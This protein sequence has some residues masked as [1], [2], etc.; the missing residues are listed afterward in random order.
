MQNEK[1]C[2]YYLRTG[3]CKFG[4]T[5]KFHHPQPSNA[6]VSI[7]GSSVYTT[8]PSPGIPG[9][10]PYSGGLTNWP[11]SRASFITG[12]RWQGPSSYAQLI[13]PQGMV[14]V[15]GWNAYPV[16][17]ISF[18]IFCLPL[19]KLNPVVGSA[20]EN[21]PVSKT[22]IWISLQG[23]M[24]SAVS[25]PGNQQQTPPRT[26]QF[27]G[28]SQQSEIT[29]SGGQGSVSS[30]QVSSVPMGVY[31]FHKENLFPERPG[32]QE[33]QY[34]MKTGDCKFGAVCRFHHPR[35]RVIPVPDCILSPLG[36]PLRPVSCPLN[37]D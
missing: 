12:T 8:V 35:E 14:Q 27:Y 30:Y 29:G 31:A 13:L 2:A 25:S 11:L 1:E 34:Y 37:P 26:G 32:E 16:S 24:G 5:C 22:K 3:S 4:D 10:Q 19:K 20:M 17:L 21:F 28:S 18:C 36:L 7:R 6:V 15:P 23:Q 9:Q 33:C